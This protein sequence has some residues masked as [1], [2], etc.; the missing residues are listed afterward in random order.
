MTT[1]MR[2]KTD[3]T[4]KRYEKVV[5]DYL[6]E[7]GSLVTCSDDDAFVK[8]IR[9]T[10]SHLKLDVRSFCR[11]VQEY[12][13]AVTLMAKLT[14]K[15]TAP[16]LVFLERR[17]HKASCIKTVKVLK[18]FYPDKIRIIVVSSETSREEIILAHEVGAD[19]FITKPI[20][21]NAII[22]KIAFTIRP[23]SQLG[24]LMDRCA[25]L[26]DSGELA[27]AE[28]V[29]ARIFEIKPDSLKG[30][31]LMGDLEARRGDHQAAEAHY[32]KA[33]KSEKLYIEPLKKLADLSQHTGDTDKRLFFLNKLDALSPLNFERKVEIGETYLARDEPDKARE[34]FEQA[35]KVVG[36]VAVDMVSESLMEIARKIGEKDE[37][38]ALTYMTEA[39]DAKGVAL[40][41]DDLWMFNNRGIA[42]RRQGKWSEAVD[43][44]AKALNLAPGDAGLYYNIGVAYADGRVYPKAW[45][46]FQ[47]ALQADGAIVQQ[48]PSVSYNI[49]MSLQKINKPVEARKYL[50]MALDLDPG[51]EPARKLMESLS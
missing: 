43:N 8:A 48:A 45:E 18:G 9:F 20:S 32:V 25:A 50:G 5:L 31:L 28:A 37:E 44:Y 41:R 17:M 4:V 19:S 23:N 29:A 30:R 12:D 11:E 34:Y 42:L 6:G 39:I 47:K 27:D 1:V 13:D 35:K 14:E 26:I 38:L 36:R 51:Y 22:E 21:A 49:A 2:L 3:Q 7:G 10:V 40:T 15:A 46:S 24:V 16:L 33:Y